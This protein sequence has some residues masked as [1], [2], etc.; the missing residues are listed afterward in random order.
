M[1]R[2]T[3]K[4]SLYNHPF[5]R[6]R[7][8][9]VA[10]LSWGY[11]KKIGKENLFCQEYTYLEQLKTGLAEGRFHWICYK[12]GDWF[13]TSDAKMYSDEGNEDF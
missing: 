2:V 9:N 3:L 13:E 5:L 8:L 4:V 10:A 12:L 6:V 1:W 7:A 11:E